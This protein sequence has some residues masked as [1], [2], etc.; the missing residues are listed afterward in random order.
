MRTDLSQFTQGEV[1]EAA[2]EVANRGEPVTTEAALEILLWWEECEAEH[3]AALEA[4]A[5]GTLEA[6]SVSISPSVLQRLELDVTTDDMIEAEEMLRR[7]DA[8]TDRTTLKYKV[9]DIVVIWMD[10]K[11][12]DGTPM[13][14]MARI[15]GVHKEDACY[16]VAEVNQNKPFSPAIVNIAVIIISLGVP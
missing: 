2:A 16:T 5:N 14:Y 7:L 13:S 8:Q 10:K 12:S 1:I 6:A 11:H 4:H 15:K 3:E 9:G